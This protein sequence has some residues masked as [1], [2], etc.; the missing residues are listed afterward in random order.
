MPVAFV[1]LDI[2]KDHIDVSVRPTAEQW[3][4]AQTDDGIAQLVT[5]L[6]DRP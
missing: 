5:R 6:R 4:A 3:Q 2:A 1:G